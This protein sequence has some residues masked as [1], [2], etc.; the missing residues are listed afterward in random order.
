MF[1]I[2]IEN[3]KLG[4]PYYDQSLVH[5][6]FVTGAGTC[7]HC[8]H[9]ILNICQ[10]QI[11]NGEVYGVG[12]DCIEKVGLPVKELTAVQKAVRVHEKAKRVARKESKG[13][14]ARN[15][16]RALIEA[17]RDAFLAKPHPKMKGMTLLDY[18]NW[19][20]EHSS[21]GGILFALT[22]IRSALNS[23]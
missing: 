11:G 12:T 10:V 21:D 9:A 18:A 19:V 17:N 23:N 16:I 7:A 3:G 6:N 2:N 13:N 15:E 1:T 22:T 14:I 8:G 4:R 20:L 5:K